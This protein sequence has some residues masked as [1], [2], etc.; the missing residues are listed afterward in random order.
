MLDLSNYDSSWDEGHEEPWDRKYAEWQ[1]RHWPSWLANHLS[2][3]FT[4]ERKEDF[5][6]HDLFNEDQAWFA[7]GHTM[8]VLAIEGED[9]DYGILIKVRQQRKTGVL[10]LADVEVT[11]RDDPNFWPVREYVVWVAN[12]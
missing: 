10:P 11:S 7:V 1:S 6:S 2:F 9:E 8:N 4:V 5:S 12:Q 3:P